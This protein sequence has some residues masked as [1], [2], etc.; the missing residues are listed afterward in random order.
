[1]LHSGALTARSS[2]ADNA[3]ARR[4]EMIFKAAFRP[5]PTPRSMRSH[6]SGAL[7]LTRRAMFRNRFCES[8]EEI[9]HFVGTRDIIQAT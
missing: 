2:F 4:L 6:R 3:A 1:M 8:S 9:G 5:W 7:P